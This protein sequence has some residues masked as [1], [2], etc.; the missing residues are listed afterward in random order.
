MQP[1]SF[2]HVPYM[3]T[4]VGLPLFLE[5]LR[6]SAK[7]HE[8]AKPHLLV[9]L[10]SYHAP[11]PPNCPCESSKT[12]PM[13]TDGLGLPEVVIPALCPVIGTWHWFGLL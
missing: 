3:H 4:E 2:L 8:V 12:Q 6:Y 7:R 9:V 10:R 1:T 5:V 13:I 11:D